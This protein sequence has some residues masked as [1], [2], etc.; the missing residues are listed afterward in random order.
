ME[1]KNTN[2]LTIGPV[3]ENLYLALRSLETA[4]SHY[5]RA[6]V[7]RGGEQAAENA[8]SRRSEFDAL[9]SALESEIMEAARIWAAAEPET[10]SI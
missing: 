1:K 8:L 2:G 9:R 10:Q 4:C 3:T 5:F 6:Y 7:A